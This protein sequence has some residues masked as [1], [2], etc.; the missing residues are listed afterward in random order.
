MSLIKLAI[1]NQKWIDAKKLVRSKDNKDAM[2]ASKSTP[3]VQVLNL[4]SH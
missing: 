2:I 3:L 1:D 4:P